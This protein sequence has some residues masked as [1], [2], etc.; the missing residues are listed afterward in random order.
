MRDIAFFELNKDREKN[1]L[2]I[3]GWAADKEK[4]KPLA[5]KLAKLSWHVVAVD[6]PGFGSTNAPVFPLTVS[7]YAKEVGKFV[8]TKFGDKPYIV[9]GHS[10]G[11][12]VAAKIAKLD[13]RVLGLVLCSSGVSKRNKVFI[14]LNKTLA[15]ILLLFPKMKKDVISRYYEWPEDITRIILRSM[16]YED[17]TPIFSGIKI[18]CLILWGESDKITPLKNAY[19]T[20]NLLPR[21]L[22]KTFPKIG[23]SLPY[24]KP[25]AVAREITTW[26]NTFHGE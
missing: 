11:G 2:L 24:K 17:S 15:N 22:I 18:P 9:F 25:A 7:G 19:L 8:D 16:R 12:R 5:E 20:K 6:L 26:S 21:S 23:H 4:L 14:F 3:H 1:I 13:K 10:F